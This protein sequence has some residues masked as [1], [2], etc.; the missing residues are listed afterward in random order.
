MPARVMREKNIDVMV[1]GEVTEW[2]LCAYVNDA[3]MLG[4]KKALLI[5]GHER[6]EEWGMKDMAECLKPLL[7]T[8]P[9]VFVDAKE[10]FQYL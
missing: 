6:S 8:L 10:P 2:T 1:C 9:V 4:M 3:Y 7:K 5:V